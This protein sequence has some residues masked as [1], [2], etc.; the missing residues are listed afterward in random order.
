MVYR[1]KRSQCS[2]VPKPIKVPQLETLAEVRKRVDLWKSE[3]PGKTE[4]LL[5]EVQKAREQLGKN[6]SYRKARVEGTPEA[7]KLAKK[8]QKV[9]IVV[10]RPL[11]S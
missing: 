5:V 10:L 4:H 11:M 7:Q 6:K 1:V 2:V 9:C 3:L 8:K